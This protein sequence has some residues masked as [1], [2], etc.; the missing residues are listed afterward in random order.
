MFADNLTLAA[1]ARLVVRAFITVECFGPSVGYFA[2]APK[3][4]SI[5][6]K[7]DEVAMRAAHD[8]EGLKPSYTQ[9]HR[10]VGVFV[11]SAAMEDEWILPQVKTW[12]NGIEAL[13]CMA[14]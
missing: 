9:G 5:C 2:S 12:V 10:Y 7:T 4:F 14:V 6:P 8:A 1:R 3:S 13:A 11:G